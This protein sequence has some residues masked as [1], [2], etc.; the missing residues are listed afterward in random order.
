M[1]ESSSSHDHSCF[2]NSEVASNSADM[3][4][5]LKAYL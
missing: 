4:V 1:N 3:S 5:L 2:S